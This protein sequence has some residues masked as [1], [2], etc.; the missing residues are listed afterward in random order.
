MPV[1][2]D[3]GAV[4]VAGRAIRPAYEGIETLLGFAVLGKNGS[5]RA[6]RPAYEGIET[7]KFWSRCR[8]PRPTVAR[9]APPMRGLKHEPVDLEC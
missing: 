1:R 6:I 2:P 7:R 3:R 8:P 4:L 5:R 9:S